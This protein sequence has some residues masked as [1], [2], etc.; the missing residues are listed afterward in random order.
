MAEVWSL[1]PLADVVDTGV[2]WLLHLPGPL[3]DI[4]RS[5]VLLTLWRCWF[6]RNEVV[7]DKVP[8]PLDVSQ[9][10]LCS[11]LDSLIALKVDPQLTQAKGK[12]WFLMISPQGRHGK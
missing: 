9:R 5:M 6:A 11:Y 2:E 4:E 1:P 7:H 10:F 3:S 8:P 12:R